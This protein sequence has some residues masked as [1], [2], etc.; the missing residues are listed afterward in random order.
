MDCSCGTRLTYRRPISI[1]SS[2]LRRE[3]WRW[4]PAFC[5]PRGEG[6]GDGKISELMSREVLERFKPLFEPKTV[7]VIGASAR[8]MTFPNIFMRRIREFGFKG[9]IYPIHPSADAIDGL[10]AYRSLADTPEPVDSAFIAVPAG[11]IPPMLRV[12]RGRVRYAQVISSGFGEVYEGKSLQTE[13]SA[14][15]REG[16][17]RL[18]GPNC[19]GMYSHRGGIV[20][21]ETWPETGGHVGAISQSGG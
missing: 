18:I 3:Q 5:L 2:F 10:P 20:F 7:A 1:P 15:A 12:A 14:A 17:M 21:S 11:Q 19:L 9:A 8:G 16:G 6:N 4:M 13:L